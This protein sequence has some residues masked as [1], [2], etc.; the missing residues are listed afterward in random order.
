[1]RP[2]PLDAKAQTPTQLPTGRA[3]IEHITSAL[4]SQAE[5]SSQFAFVNGAQTA[6]TEPGSI[7]SRGRNKIEQGNH[8]LWFQPDLQSAL[9]AIDVN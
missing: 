4:P 9:T 1:M 6:G 7:R 5:P 2:H 3:H 8:V